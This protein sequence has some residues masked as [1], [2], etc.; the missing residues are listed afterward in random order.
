[1]HLYTKKVAAG[2]DV[3]ICGAE[4]SSTKSALTLIVYE[5]SVA[6][7]DMIKEAGIFQ[8]LFFCKTTFVRFIKRK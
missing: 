1:M 2:N 5:K 8:G 6:I 3:L 7:S 4:L